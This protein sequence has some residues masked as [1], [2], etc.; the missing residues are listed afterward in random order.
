MIIYFII[1]TGTNLSIIGNSEGMISLIDA[2]NSHTIMVN[3]S[4]VA[5]K[6]IGEIPLTVCNKYGVKQVDSC[7]RQVQL[8]PGSPFHLLSSNWFIKNGLH[9][10]GNNYEI[11]FLK[12]NFKLVC[13]IKIHTY[14]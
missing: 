8:V 2:S 6:G 1:D 11:I 4:K 9:L 12:G 14:L 5:A 3:G 7:I 13:D 10:F